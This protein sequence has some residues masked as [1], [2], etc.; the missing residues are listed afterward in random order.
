VEVQARNARAEAQEVVGD[1]FVASVLEPSPP[2]VVEAPW[3][4]D[5]PFRPVPRWVE[6]LAAHPEHGD[7]AAERWLDD[8]RRLSPA[9]A[10]LGSTR[11][12][13]HRLAVYVLSPARRRA[14]GKIALRWTLGGFGTPFFG[15]D[16]QV[17][18]QGV[19]LVRQQ[20]GAA[21]S[22]PITTL[23]AAARFVLDGP[24]DLAW[25]ASY[26]VP[27]PGDPDAPLDVDR[28][29]AAFLGDWYGFATSVLE[30]LRAE[31][32]S[33]DESRVQI[34]PE[35]FDVAFDCLPPD[36]RATFG[37]S[38]GD[39]RIPQPYFY[40]LP[41]AVDGSELWNADTFAGAILPLDAFVGAADQRAVV[42]DFLRVRRDHLLGR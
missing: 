32:T 22:E 25:A 38:P 36:R 35:H 30:A 29:A 37:A 34:W 18:A 27:P 4:A 1:G 39:A 26:D 13:L 28:G 24:P 15:E 8:G 11:L 9:P 19:Q 41:P 5:D 3:F 7:W 12:A 21:A 31:P 16:E 2:A 14:N 33:T 6:W 17:R 23:T 20:G 10:S 42:L 40:V